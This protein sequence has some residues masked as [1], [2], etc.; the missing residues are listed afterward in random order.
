VEQRV[1]VCGYVAVAIRASKRREIK[2]GIEPLRSSLE[3]HC[4][5]IDLGKTV[6]R[7][8]LTQRQK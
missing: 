4:R 1:T 5:G 7:T 3:G 8:L 2:G 6:A